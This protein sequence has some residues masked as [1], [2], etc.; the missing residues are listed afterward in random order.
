M[1]CVGRRGSHGPALA[2][3]RVPSRDFGLA[4]APTGWLADR[5]RLDPALGSASWD[6]RPTPDV[7]SLGLCLSD[8]W[9][10]AAGQLLQASHTDHRG[11][12]HTL[13][14]WLPAYM[15]CGHLQVIVE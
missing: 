15:T 4:P 12:K 2:R 9:R 3:A 1:C 10:A 8:Q 14:L 13:P 11:H 7:L 5:L 6:A